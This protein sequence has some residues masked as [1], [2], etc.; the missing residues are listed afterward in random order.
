MQ[1]KAR[2]KKIEMALGSGAGGSRK[3][4]RRFEIKGRG[5]SH[6]GAP[7]ITATESARKFQ[8]RN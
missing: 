4:R 8:R 5:K 2:T 7:R 6:T 3:G 1:M